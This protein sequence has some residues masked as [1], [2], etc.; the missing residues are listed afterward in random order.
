MN[1]FQKIGR[2]IDFLTYQD[3]LQLVKMHNKTERIVNGTAVQRKIMA[4]FSLF[5]GK[6]RATMVERCISMKDFP[7][8]TT[9]AGVASL[10][11][12]EIPYRE[13]AYITIRDVQ[14]G[15]LAELLQECV[16][17]CRMA[18]AERIYAA[19]HE[20]LES[21]PL[22]TAVYEMRGQA[23]VDQEKVENL[24]PVT[25]ATVT[26]WRRIYNEKMRTVD[27]AATQ[28]AYDEKEIVSSGGAYFVHHSGEL[29]GIGWLRDT[30]LLAVCGVKPG[31]G[32]RVMHTLMSLVEGDQMTL[33]V[34]STNERAIR[35]YE[36]LGF[37]KVRE[38]KRW[39]RVI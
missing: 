1:Y 23:L 16:S 26:E 9:E 24:F 21:Y 2:R 14:P 8:F 17:F 10:V 11:L 33:E 27:C 29:L 18:G 34:A 39:Y 25:D 15:Q 37:I 22:H 32:E 3:R 7:F 31:A 30:E 35:L 20:K 4:K 28:T 38:V 19:G 36:R 13:E 6:S 5:R 12:K